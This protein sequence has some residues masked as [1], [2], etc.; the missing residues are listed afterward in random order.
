L[1]NQSGATLFATVGGV[2]G[3]W[4]G[5]ETWPVQLS[6]GVTLHAPDIFF[7]PRGQTGAFVL[8][9][10]GPADQSTVTI[11]GDSTTSTYC[12]VGFDSK[13]AHSD[14]TTV[15]VDDSLGPNRALP[16]ALNWVWMNGSQTGLDIGPGATVTATVQ[17]GGALSTNLVGGFPGT[18]ATPSGTT[19]IHCRGQFGF[20]ATFGGEIT[21]SHQSTDVMAEDSCS[22]TFNLSS[23]GGDC[24]SKT[25]DTGISLSG[26]ASVTLFISG[27]SCVRGDGILLA[28]GS[29]SFST[30]VA[31][32]SNCG[33][34]GVHVMAGTASLFWATVNHNHYGVIQE[35]G[36]SFSVDPKAAASRITCST[37][38]EPGTCYGDG[39]PGVDV[40]NHSSTA[41][42]ATDTQWDHPIPPVLT[43]SDQ[44]VT[45][46]C[47]SDAG[48]GG[49]SFDGTDVAITP[50]SNDDSGTV[51]TSQPDPIAWG[52]GCN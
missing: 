47:S 9:S 33:C 15:A 24:A 52:G 48:C 2:G 22:A 40:W 6:L 44:F 41:L 12:Y 4:T 17:A 5:T 13:G 46:S 11:E 42:G 18:A 3:D 23:F 38:L 1:A 49:V 21:V 51:D 25:D 34:A 36:G 32:I 35:T 30:N 31:D 50:D 37:N 20:P 45:C 29:P 39:N 10:S 28:S 19:G 27:V 16:L 26:S 43:C 7:A 8:Q 14:G